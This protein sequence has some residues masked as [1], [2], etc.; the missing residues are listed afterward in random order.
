MHEATLRGS[1]SP[2]GLYVSHVRYGLLL[3]AG[4]RTSNRGQVAKAASAVA[5]LHVTD[6]SAQPGV[7]GR[8]LKQAGCML[9]VAGGGW[10]WLADRV[11]GR[12][13]QGG[14][15]KGRVSRPKESSAARPLRR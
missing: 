3:S 10:G 9:G 5:A 11:E 15:G 1:L 6:L 7:G 8:E 4:N 12:E 2:G 14:W 13:G